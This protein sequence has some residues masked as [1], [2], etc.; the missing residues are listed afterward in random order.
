MT[1]LLYNR[2]ASAALASL[3]AGG[4]LPHAILLEGPAGSGKHLAAEII[5]RYALCTAPEKPCGHCTGCMKVEKRIHPDVRYYGV[6]EGKKEFPIDLVREI[7]QDA[8]IA[9]NEG[10]CKLYILEQA[11][12]MNA[13]AQNALLKSI[14]EPPPHARFVLLCENRS[15]LLPTIL[16]R[17]T[18]IEL[19]IPSVEQCAQAL[20]TLAPDTPEEERRAAAAGAGGNIGRA[21]ELLGSA[22]PSKA[23][24]DARQLRET[25]VFGERYQALKIL[26]AYDKDRQGLL[27][28]LPLL[29]E[30]FAQAA[31]AR[32]RPAAGGQEERLTNRLTCEQAICAAEAA[33]QAAEQ[34]RR[35][36]SVPLL[37]ACMVERIKAAVGG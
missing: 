26:A 35:N 5:A 20:E 8:Y 17:V 21:L 9:P 3:G 30:G 19:E 11:H 27:D 25:L 4:R 32:Y 14:E 22:K 2:K 23:A 16:S 36:V 10:A 15:M 28:L 37:C 18:A 1:G 13:A 33:A 24:A 12:A 29:E 31:L 7:R 34:A 6:P